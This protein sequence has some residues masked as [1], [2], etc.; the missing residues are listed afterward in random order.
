[1]KAINILWDV[2]DED[3]NADFLPTEVDI[4]QPLEDKDDEVIS[5]YLTDLTGF[6]HKGF[7]LANV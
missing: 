5:D 7:E 2:D 1:M 4:P 3:G 6:C